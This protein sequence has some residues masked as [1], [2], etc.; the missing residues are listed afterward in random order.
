MFEK[1]LT[2]DFKQHAYPHHLISSAICYFL[3]QTF[4]GFT[5]KLEDNVHARF[6]TYKELI[7]GFS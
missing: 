7:F 5:E 4:E 6:A 3:L 2:H 1:V